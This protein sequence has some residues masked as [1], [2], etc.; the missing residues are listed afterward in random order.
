VLFHHEGGVEIGDVDAKVLCPTTAC[1]LRMCGMLNQ[2][3][4]EFGS[5]GIGLES[6]NAK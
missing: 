6:E 2:L 4:R 3:V 1:L 5:R